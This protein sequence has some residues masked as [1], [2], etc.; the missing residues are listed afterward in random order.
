[1]D[2][3]Y[4]EIVKFNPYTV[5]NGVPVTIKWASS[6]S[7]ILSDRKTL[8]SINNSNS[9][10]TDSKFHLM[11]YMPVYSN[12]IQN[13]LNVFNQHYCTITTDFFTRNIEYHYVDSYLFNAHSTYYSTLPTPLSL[14]TL[15][16]MPTILIKP[17]QNDYNLLNGTGIIGN[18]IMNH[19]WLKMSIY[20]ANFVPS[21]YY[22]LLFLILFTRASRNDL[23]EK[24]SLNQP[25]K[26]YEVNG[27]Y[28]KQDEQLKYRDYKPELDEVNQGGFL[29]FN[30]EGIFEVFYDLVHDILIN[31][32]ESIY[33]EKLE[34]RRAELQPGEE[35][36]DLDESD[37]Q[38]NIESDLE[39]FPD[40]FYMDGF[41]AGQIYDFEELIRQIKEGRFEMGKDD[42][43]RDLLRFI[44]TYETEFRY[45]KL[46]KY[47]T[48]QYVTIYNTSPSEKKDIKNGVQYIYEG[49]IPKYN[50]YDNLTRILI[51]FPVMCLEG[52]AVQNI[53]IPIKGCV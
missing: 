3:L 12:I 36:D 13:L 8:D 43:I 25:W 31:K 38:N 15:D 28:P 48:R 7:K 20:L 29:L 50:T 5:E 37:R 26:D 23:T 17:A 44:I 49:E 6:M 30:L 24:V 40:L 27:L 22:E 10:G 1:M 41:D 35:L 16:L 47:Y 18:K 45:Y 33:Y 34:N 11:I 21:P 46:D 14:D 53:F 4:K 2:Q 52:K 42:I 51:T 39:G 19:D 9:V 32:V